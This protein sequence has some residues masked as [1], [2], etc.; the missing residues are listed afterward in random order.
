MQH[1][2]DHH[3]SF[4]E[5]IKEYPIMAALVSVVGIGVGYASTEFHFPLWLMQTFQIGAWTTA[6]LVAMIPIYD[7]FVKRIIPWIKSFKKK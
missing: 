7:T 4:I 6:I 5:H 1:L 2:I 3:Q